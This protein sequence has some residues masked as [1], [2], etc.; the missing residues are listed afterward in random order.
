MSQKPAGAKALRQNIKARVRNLG[1]KNAIK[2]ASVQ[3]RKA[4]TAKNLTEAATI[5]A[6]L[7][8][9]YDKA[10]QKKV[11]HRNL[12][13]RRKSRLLKRLKTAQA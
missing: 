3:L 11:M 1:V 6:S 9:A 10:A 4:Y 5:T 12:A 13:A 7:I 2:K 8:R